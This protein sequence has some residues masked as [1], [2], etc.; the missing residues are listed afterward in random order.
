MSNT[1]NFE[2]AQTVDVSSKYS[3]GLKA[4]TRKVFNY[5]MVSLGL[6]GLVSYL[7]IRTDLS[8]LFLAVKSNG[9]VGYSGLGLLVMWAPLVIVLF[10]SFSRSLSATGTKIAMFS[11]AA[12]EGASLS[13]LILSAGVNNAFQAFLITGIL[14]G[15]MSLYGY[16][17][18][19]DLL[20]MGQIL[21]MGVW[22][23]VIVSVVSF[24]TGGVG[25]WFSYLTVILFTGLIAYEVQQ[26]KN[27]YAFTGG[28]GE[29]A[30]KLAT[31]CALSLYLDF[32]NIFMALLRIL[33]SNRE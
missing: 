33:G 29:Q 16:T 5:M 7:M 27:I 28:K 8:R 11:V 2:Y 24:F 21:I 4:Y 32:L 31:F 6:T 13:L 30:D 1:R 25:I 22:G 9:S 26:I 20:K 18:N 12:L 14:F 3:E 23:L 10:M 17:T 19:K 15:F